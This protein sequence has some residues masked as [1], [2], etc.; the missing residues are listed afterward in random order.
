MEYMWIVWLA[1]AIFF[2]IIESI[3]VEL[4]SI[5][6]TGGSLIALIVSLIVPE[7][8]WQIAAFC[9]SSILLIIFTRPIVARYLKRNES[10]TNVDSLI[11]GIATVT[12]DILPDDRG[13]VKVNG[14][15]WLAISSENVLIESGNKVSILAIE[16]AK[17]IVKKYE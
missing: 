3:T 16:G 17:L 2:L 13:E 9:V 1:I 4:I 14:Q 11:G 8:G 6:F 7:L 5:W 15:Y 12:K 10:K